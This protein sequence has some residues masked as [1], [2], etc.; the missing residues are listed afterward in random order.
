MDMLVF[1]FF[2]VNVGV[3]IEV[4][5]LDMFGGFFIVFVVEWLGGNVVLLVDI[6]IIF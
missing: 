4:F 6:C 2:F 1:I 5:V 3:N